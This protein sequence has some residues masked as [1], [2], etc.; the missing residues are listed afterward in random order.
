MEMRELAQDPRPTAP[1]HI[2]VFL[3]DLSGGGAER[4][5]VLLMNALAASNRV[6]LVLARRE[7]PYLADL[8]PA[9]EVVDLG[10]VRTAGGIWRLA[11][12]LKLRRPDVLMSHMTHVNVAA[13][14]AALLS[15]TGTPVVAVEHNQIDLNYARLTSRMVKAAYRATRWT[16]PRAA[17]VVCVSDGVA[18]SIAAFSG[19]ARERLRVIANPIVTPELRRLAAEPPTHPWLRERSV[20]VVLGCGRLVEQKDFETLIRAFRIVRDARTARLLILGEGLLREPLQALIRELGLSE[21]AD[22]PGFDR[23]PFAAMAASDLFVLSSRWE[24]LPTVLIEALAAG[25]PVAATDCPSGPMEVLRG[26]E[27]GPLVPVGDAG[28]LAKAILGTLDAP[29][30]RSARLERAADYTVERAAQ[31]YQRLFESIAA[32]AGRRPQ[33]I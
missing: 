22:L 4:V 18:G 16:Y 24:G 20:P 14:A 5:A 8:D 12:W 30:P 1:A 19:I 6:S 28:A 33:T 10:G 26:G 2:A 9:I 23:N 3:Q 7:G 17:A 15:G 29:G 13:I 11:Q 32:R 31:A 27:L 25:A 21:D